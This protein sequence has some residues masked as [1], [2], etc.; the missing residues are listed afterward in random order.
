MSNSARKVRQLDDVLSFAVRELDHLN[1]QETDIVEK[2]FKDSGKNTKP[3]LIIE[4]M[5][6]EISKVDCWLGISSAPPTVCIRNL[7]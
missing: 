1:K 2:V 7:T 3:E 5:Q 4:P 6:K